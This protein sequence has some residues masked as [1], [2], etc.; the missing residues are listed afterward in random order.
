MIRAF[1]K[2]FWRK[3]S[4]EG[5]LVHSDR[6]VQY[7]SIDFR[8]LLKEKK[9]VQSMSRKGNCWDDTVVELFF[10]TLKTQLVYQRR[11]QNSDEREQALNY[12]KICYNR[13]RRHSIIGYQSPAMYE[14]EWEKR[15]MLLNYLSIKKVVR[16]VAM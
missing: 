15:K 14:S 3:R 13:S 2:A 1:Q 5:L 8:K 7:V 6:A 4:G 16:S 9:F 12:I 10:H 11:F